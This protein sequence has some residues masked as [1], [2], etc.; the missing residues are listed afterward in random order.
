M[1]FHQL[2]M[3][4]RSSTRML[5]K[6]KSRTNPNPRHSHIWKKGM[7]Q[8]TLMV[9]DKTPVW[10]CAITHLP[11]LVEK[12]WES[13]GQDSM[14]GEMEMLRSSKKCR[15]LV[16]TFLMSDLH[17]DGLCSTTGAYMF[18]FQGQCSVYSCSGTWFELDL[19]S[20][21]CGEANRTCLQ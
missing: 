20:L 4:G 15:D 17:S 13:S 10:T 21:H 11:K 1:K 14:V 8:I 3:Q 18:E 12:H 19:M 9:Q 5:E 16:L 6:S 7:C 2:G